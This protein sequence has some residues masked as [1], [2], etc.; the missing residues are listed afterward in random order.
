MWSKDK[1]LL[2]DRLADSLKGKIEYVMEGGHDLSFDISHR[3]SNLSIEE[4]FCGKP[5][6]KK[7][8]MIN[9]SVWKTPYK[10]QH[11]KEEVVNSTAPGYKAGDVVTMVNVEKTGNGGL[12]GLILDTQ[13]KITVPKFALSGKTA[14]EFIGRDV[15]V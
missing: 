14:G 10:K 9:V 1:K 13:T 2:E 4:L 6:K 7:E 5:M 3:V 11:K 15:L 12:R 8:S